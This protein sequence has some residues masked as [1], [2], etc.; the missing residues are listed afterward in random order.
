[1]KKKL[2]LMSE[3]V[4]RSYVDAS[5]ELQEMAKGMSAQDIKENTAF[6]LQSALI[7]EIP[8][9]GKIKLDIDNEG[10]AHIPITGILTNTV[11]PSAAFEGQA[12]TTYNFIIESI[13]LAEEDPRVKEIIFETNTGGGDVDGVEPTAIAIAQIKKPTIARVHSSSQSAG[14]LL[15]TQA[16]EIVAVGR[17]SL[18]GSVGV[19]AEFKD[20]SKAEEMR[21][22]KS[23]ILTSTDAPEKRLDITTDEGQAATI[24]L[25]D[26]VHAV[27]VGH[28]ARGRGLTTE[29]VNKNF[30]R[31]G[32]MTAERALAVGMIDRIEGITILSK[33]SNGGTLA[34]SAET[35]KDL[36]ETNPTKE[37]NM[38]Q[39]QPMTLSEFLALP[40]NAQAKVDHN[41]L[42]ADAKK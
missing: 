11:T 38:A 23:I 21:G 1:M 17:M 39:V 41:N 6:V 28:I 19:A 2:H 3:A 13:A 12:I 32:T 15:S 25:M 8:E 4:L 7:N 20:R 30:G 10:S 42:L 5:R 9:D 35:P 40:E 37:E 31:G 18:F 27:M 33:T 36:P 14:I 26:E 29:F 34:A 22:V 16:D 24:K